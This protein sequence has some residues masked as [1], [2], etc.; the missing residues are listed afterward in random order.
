MLQT[1]FNRLFDWARS[2]SLRAGSA[3]LRRAVRRWIFRLLAVIVCLLANMGG[4]IPNYKQKSR[5]KWGKN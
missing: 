5:K 2:T 3:G 1:R 4:I